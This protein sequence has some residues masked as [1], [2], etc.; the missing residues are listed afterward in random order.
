MAGIEKGYPK[1]VNDLGVPVIK[2]GVRE[3]ECMGAHP[4]HDHPHVFLDMGD[5]TQIVCPYCGT[6]YQYDPG[7]ARLECLPAE[8]LY[9]VE[10][11]APADIA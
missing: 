11:P 6:R 4:P 10:E 3:F 8:C 7:F 2:I 9:D 1:F 5:D